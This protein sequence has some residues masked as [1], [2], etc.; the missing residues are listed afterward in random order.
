MTM[1]KGRILEFG[2]QFER[3]VLLAS[4]LLVTYT[5]VGAAISEIQGFPSKL[6]HHLIVLLE[7]VK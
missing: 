2:H 7:G 6:K 3:A 5:N 1:D 4:V